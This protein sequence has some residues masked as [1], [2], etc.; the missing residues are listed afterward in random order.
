VVRAGERRVRRARKRFLAETEAKL[1]LAREQ[2]DAAGIAAHTDTVAELRSHMLTA[3]KMTEL[4]RG[5][6]FSFKDF[7]PNMLPLHHCQ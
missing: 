6:V 1:A 2:R 5:V 7:T 3:P 4:F